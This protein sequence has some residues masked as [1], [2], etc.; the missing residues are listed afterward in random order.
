MKVCKLPLGCAPDSANPNMS[1]VLS[2]KV[3]CNF[4]EVFV[5]SMHALIALFAL[6]QDVGIYVFDV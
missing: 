3:S 2:N 4:L 6:P 5:V 1:Q